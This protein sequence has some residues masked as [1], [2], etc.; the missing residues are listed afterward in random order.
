MNYNW[1]WNT[2]VFYDR[3]KG[4]WSR[5]LLS[6]N[7]SSHQ[8]ISSVQVDIEQLLGRWPSSSTAYSRLR[9]HVNNR[10]TFERVNVVLLWA[11]ATVVADETNIRFQYVALPFSSIAKWLR[12]ILIWVYVTEL[13]LTTAYERR[14]NSV[15]KG[16]CISFTRK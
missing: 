15:K 3:H 5:H 9:K 10:K 14:K 12:P 8:T 16:F 7:S 13:G 6:A 11:F 2:E 1:F 4:I